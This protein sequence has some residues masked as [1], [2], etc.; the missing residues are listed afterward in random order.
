MPWIEL[1]IKTT[2]DYADSLSDQLSLL[3][4]QAV[5]FQDAGDQPIYEPVPGELNL[6]QETIVIG[7]FD[8]G[9]Q[10]KPILLYL[11]EQQATGLIKAFQLKDIADRDW[12][13]VCLEHFKPMQFGQR[14]WVCPSWQTPPDLHAVNVI[15]DPGLAFG[16]GTHPTTGL[17]LE[18]L[19]QHIQTEQLVIDY[20]CGSGILGLAALKLG[21]KAVIAVDN[22]PQA[23]QATQKNAARN[24]A[25]MSRLKTYLPPE[26]TQLKLSADI[27]IANI[28]AKPLIDLAQYFASLTHEGSDLLL[29][30]ILA[31]QAETV[32]S[33]YNQWFSFKKPLTSRNGWVRLEGKRM[34]ATIIR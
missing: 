12:E 28:L 16:T 17:C 31:E 20:G 3:G 1:H 34:V 33:V 32:I 27:L 9:L 25:V 22:D 15:L 11:E 14:L 7:L 6:W 26:L 5:T 29:S 8:Y 23:L 24:Q 4:A 2:A 21:A 19:D 30:G 13:R 10:P 18:W